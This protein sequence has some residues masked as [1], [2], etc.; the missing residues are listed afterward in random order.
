M[1]ILARQSEFWLTAGWLILLG[2]VSMAFINI[3]K[4]AIMNSKS[5][6]T[7]QY[8]TL[9]YTATT[10]FFGSIYVTLWGFTIPELLPG[11]FRAACLGALLNIGIQFCNAKAAS[12]NAGEV[13]LTAPLQ[14]MTPGL[15]TILALTLGEYPNA[16]GIA[17]IAI[18]ASGSW[19]LMFQKTPEGAYE[20]LGPIRELKY[21]WMRNSR[22]SMR[23]DKAQSVMTGKARVVRL[24]VLSA[25]L[26]TFGLLMDGLF[27]R[28]GINLQGLA[29]GGGLFTGIFAVAYGT[30]FAVSPDATP[31]Q[32][33]KAIPYF[34]AYPGILLL[35][36]VSIAWVLHV[37]LINPAYTHTYVAYVGTLKRFSILMSVVLGHLLFKEQ[38]F[39]KRLWAALLIVAGA[40]L[41][42]ADELPARLSVR[43]ESLGF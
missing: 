7:L 43:I 38:D 27:T 40:I 4:R 17:G 14:A 18:M 41:I 33:R 15:I 19:I 28:R 42:S 29:F 13:S 30:W 11:F 20:Y 8:L 16:L 24:A 1:E 22:G 25:F 12:L 2:T 9:W 39:K 32:K 21:L 6:S 26:G 3:F 23:T 5:L 34:F 35:F 10:I 31:E 36:G 37:L